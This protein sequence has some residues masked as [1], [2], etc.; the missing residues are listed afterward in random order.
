MGRYWGHSR[1]RYWGHSRNAS[2]GP[3]GRSPKTKQRGART[4]NCRIRIGDVPPGPPQCA[5]AS[6]AARTWKVV[7]RSRRVM[8]A[9][10][11]P[12]RSGMSPRVAFAPDLSGGWAGVYRWCRQVADAAPGNFSDS[13]ILATHDLVIIHVDADVSTKSYASAGIH[14]QQ[15]DDLPCKKPCPPSRDTTDALQGVLKG[16]LGQPSRPTNLAFCIPSMN[17]GAWALPQFG[18][19][20][21]YVRQSDWECRQDPEGQLGRLPRQERFEKNRRGYRTKFADMVS[22]WQDVAERLHE[23]R[24][25]M[26]DVTAVL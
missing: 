9:A 14:D 25:F 1:G 3:A 24:R 23:A 7:L 26:S 12:M 18:G 5:S 8:S 10:V 2:Y 21:R 19:D 17:M 11:R 20:N 6:P 13:K 15:H 4:R 22:G 16:W